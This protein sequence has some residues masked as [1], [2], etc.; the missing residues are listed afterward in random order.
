M[1]IWK[2]YKKSGQREA[3]QRGRQGKKAGDGGNGS[4]GCCGPPREFGQQ[5]RLNQEWGGSRGCG[6]QQWSGADDGWK[7][8]WIG[9]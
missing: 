7:A 2:C 1:E 8:S 5:V 4:D 9:G 3:A 6:R